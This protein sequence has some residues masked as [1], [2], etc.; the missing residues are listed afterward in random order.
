MQACRLGPLWVADGNTH[1]NRTT[2][3]FRLWGPGHNDGATQRASDWLQ[4]PT[5]KPAYG[6]A[7]VSWPKRIQSFNQYPMPLPAEAAAAAAARAICLCV[8]S[9]PQK[10]AAAL[11]HAPP[12]TCVQRKLWLHVAPLHVVHCQT[13][14]PALHSAACA[15]TYR[16]VILCHACTQEVP[17][18]LQQW[19]HRLRPPSQRVADAAAC[20]ATHKRC[21]P[22]CRRCSR[23]CSRS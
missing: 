7:P 5:L 17:R 22:D 20:S 6:L 3:H 14:N 4:P 2:C 10:H 8:G 13:Q 21:H 18:E 12:S 19:L 9:Q 11:Q 16:P 15:A 1:N 23:S